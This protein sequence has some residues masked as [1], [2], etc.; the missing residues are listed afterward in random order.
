MTR[1]QK[2]KESED[3]KLFLQSFSMASINSKI[4]NATDKTGTVADDVESQQV[5]SSLWDRT[6]VSYEPMKVVKLPYYFQR[7]IV[8]GPGLLASHQFRINS[9][10]DPDLTGG[11]HQPLGRDT[12]S[13]IYDYYKVLETHVHVTHVSTQYV[14]GTVSKTSDS[15]LTDANGGS[16]Y[17][18]PAYV[19]GMLDV[20]A[21]PPNSLTEWQEVSQVTSNSQCRFTPP[22]RFE[23]VGSRKNTTVYYNMKWTPDMFDTAILNEATMD[24]WTPVGSNPQNINYFSNIVF[25]SNS[26]SNDI[27]YSLEVKIMFL[28]AFKNVKRELLYTTN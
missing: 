20:T 6:F 9:L 1:K 28:V 10:Y 21:T 5:I 14:T 25:N 27:I 18:A 26:S 16:A 7:H 3:F 15:V 24:T 8:Q 23:R 12:Y 2:K 17:M 13:A 22:Q 11:G 19:G 4:D